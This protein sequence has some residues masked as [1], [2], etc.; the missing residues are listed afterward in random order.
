MR[1][2]REIRPVRRVEV[3]FDTGDEPNRSAESA[4]GRYA[5]PLAVAWTVLLLALCLAPARVI[6]DEKTFSL[7]RYIPWYDLVVHFTLFAGFALNWVRAIRSPR[8][9][10]LV[11]AAGLILALGTEWAQGHPYIQRDPNLLDGLADLA[12]LAA[13]LAAA[14]LFRRRSA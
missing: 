6:P 11:P 4:P 3:S 8:R 14:A 5:L 2:E 12:G 10:A 13:G 7:K 9:W 1:G